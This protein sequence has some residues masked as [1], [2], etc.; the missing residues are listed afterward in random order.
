MKLFI[1]LWIKWDFVPILH[2]LFL[3]ARSP[4][5]VLPF[6]DILELVI[7]QS[8]SPI[9]SHSQSRVFDHKVIVKFIFH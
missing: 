7:L 8:R 4:F 6:S 3:R 2:F 5:P 1:G 9:V